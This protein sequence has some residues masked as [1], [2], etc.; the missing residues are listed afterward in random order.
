[1]LIGLLTA[2][3]ATDGKAHSGP[4][5]DILI[6][7]AQKG[8]ADAFAALHARYYSRIYRLAYLKTNNA[9][10][11]ED[12]ASETFLRALNNLSRF[13]FPEGQPRAA[14]T[15][16]PWLHR[17]ACNLIVDSARRRPPAPMVSLDAPVVE[18]M[19]QLLADRITSDDSTMAPQEIVERQE[20]Q[21]LVRDAIAS[22][23]DDHSD[24]LIYRFLSE[25]PLREIAPLMGGRSESAVKSLL[26]RA[27]VSLRAELTRR[28]STSDHI[29]VAHDIAKHQGKEDLEHVGRNRLGLH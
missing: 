21:Q 13:H 25:L 6:R 29:G 1:M 5:D 7:S 17:I 19:R 10:D 23:P 20:V 22:L 14:A 16:Y 12:V 28:L 18:G 27:V 15:F 11:A 24:V 3:L 26:H 8:S 2:A 9:S 4:S